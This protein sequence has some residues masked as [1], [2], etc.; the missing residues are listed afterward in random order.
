VLLQ[1]RAS[2]QGLEQEF[3]L[4]SST[5]ELST[6]DSRGFVVLQHHPSVKKVLVYQSGDK[7][8]Q[9]DEGVEINS[10][11]GWLTPTWM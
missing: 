2:D 6:F 1:S 5:V 11:S 7:P 3:M 9:L 8:E 10:K 4:S